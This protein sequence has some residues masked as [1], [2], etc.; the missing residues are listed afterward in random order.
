MVK[1]R[2]ECVEPACLRHTFT[3]TTVEL[4]L[5]ARRTTQLRDHDDRPGTKPRDGHPN[6]SGHVVN[7]P[8]HDQR[9]SQ[10]AAQQQ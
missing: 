9:H 3:Q 5:R 6:S 10:H 4:P 1:P 7:R 8:G 2:L